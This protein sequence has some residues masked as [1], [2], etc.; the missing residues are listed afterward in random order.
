MFLR[1]R[2]AIILLC[3]LTAVFVAPTRA[4]ENTKTITY[5]TPVESQITAATGEELWTLEAP[6]EDRIAIMVERTS[7]NLLPNVEF[8]D[9][10]NQVVY[11]ADQD[12]S[13]AIAAIREFTLPGAGGYTIAVRCDNGP[14]D[15]KTTGGYKL[16]VKLL[17]A[18][19]DNPSME[20][21]A[22]SVTYDA[23]VTGEIIGAHWREQWTFTA[24][25]QDV[26]SIEV[27]RT[28]AQYSPKLA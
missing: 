10:N 18:A 4:Q 3:L 11:N 19:E 16:T 22:Q 21:D 26:V 13:G 28:G 27:V 5:D 7:G 2:F 12:N 23:P 20:A 25:G 17:G 8:R 15:C 1:N 24:T 9:S 14:T 6:A